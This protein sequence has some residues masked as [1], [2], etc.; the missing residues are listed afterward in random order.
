MTSTRLKTSE[1]SIIVPTLNEESNID[2]LA[3]NLAGTG[4]ELLLVDGGSSDGTV[5]AAE[6]R[7]LRVV[8]SERGRGKQ[9]NT[10]AAAAKGQILLFLH[11]DTR[12]PP[13]FADMVVTA[14]TPPA[15]AAGAFKLAITDPTFSMPLIAALANLRSRLF[16]LPYGDQAIFLLREK[17]FAHGMYPELPI[18]ED[19]VFIREIGKKGD[20]VILDEYALT[21]SRRWRNLGVFRTTVINQLVIAGYHLNIPLERLASLYRR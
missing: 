2:A 21:S 15:V 7:G 6:Q 5:A 1:I 19:Y 18:M 16:R 3:Q 10:G 14:L 13:G 20:I 9:L 4:V 12:L 17:F 11:A 8:S